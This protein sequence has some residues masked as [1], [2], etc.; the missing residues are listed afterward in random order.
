MRKGTGSLKWS[1]Q[2]EKIMFYIWTVEA[3]FSTVPALQ[4]LDLQIDE[5]LLA[6][7]FLCIAAHVVRGSIT[8]A[9]YE[10]VQANKDKKHTL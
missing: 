6:V 8:Q 2:G 3:L 4:K 1:I 5:R 9:D 7:H 10:R